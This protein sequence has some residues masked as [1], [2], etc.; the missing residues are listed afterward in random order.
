MIAALPIYMS[1]LFI[2]FATVTTIVVIVVEL[3]RWRTRTQ[4]ISKTNN[5]SEGEATM[6][7]KEGTTT[8]LCLVC[9]EPIT[10]PQYVID[11]TKY[12]GQ[13]RC[14][15]CTSILHIKKAGSDIGEYRIVHE[16]LGKILEVY[17]DLLAA[18]LKKDGET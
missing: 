18:A 16:K 9:N 10:F 6:G 13:I 11:S 15:A 12:S 17:R 14:Q 3:R 4:S 8:V 2:F 5:L 7:K 1:I